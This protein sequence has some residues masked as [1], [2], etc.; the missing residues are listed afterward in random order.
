[1]RPKNTFTVV[2]LAI[3]ALWLGSAQAQAQTKLPQPSAPVV[4]CGVQAAPAASSHKVQFDSGT[5]EDVQM[6]TPTTTG[7]SG[8]IVAWCNANAPAGWTH[9]FTL[10]AARFTLGDHAVVVLSI[11]SFGQTTGIAWAI[12]I[13]IKPGPF[14]VTAAGQLPGED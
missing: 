9:A 14:A 10:P 13:G 12:N 2:L 1:M 3:V 8:A 5:P 7:T 4:F 6:V 11:N